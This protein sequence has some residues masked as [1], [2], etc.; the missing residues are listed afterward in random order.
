VDGALNA[1]ESALDRHVEA[2]RGEAIALIWEGEEGEIRRYTYRQVFEEVARLAG[3]LRALGVQPGDRIG[4]F[5]PMI[6]EVAFALLAAMRIG[7]IVIPLFS[8]FGPEAVAVRLQDAE[9]RF[10]ITADGFPRRGRIVPMKEIADEALRAAPSVEKVLVVRRAGNPSPWREG[11]DLWLHEVIGRGAPVHEAPAFPS[12]TPFMIIYTSGTTGRPKGTVHVH[13]G[14]PIKA[15][16]DM[17]HLF[18]VKPVDVIHWVTD[19]GWMMG[20]WLILGSLTLGATCLIYDGAPDHPEPDRLWELVERHGVT[21]LGVSP[22][23]IRALMR[24]GTEWP[25]RHAMP[26]LRLLGSTGEPWNPEPWLWTFQHVGKGR[27]PIINYSGGTEI[28]GGILG[29]T[30]LRPSNPAPSTPSSPA[31]RRTAWTRPGGRCGKRWAS[32]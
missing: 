6:P 16:Q 21:I 28:F 15:A 32:W 1:T 19:I 31:S 17:F 4:L 26:S 3:A 29:C 27:C 22:T 2:G 23:L 14:A 25:D 7:A 12:E 11:R 24:A 18:D 8:G 9:A 10:L 30:V 13:G 20:P 5:L